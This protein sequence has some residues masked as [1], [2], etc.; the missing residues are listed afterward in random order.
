M[1]LYMIAVSLIR[2]KNEALKKMHLKRTIK[3]FKIVKIDK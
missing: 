1:S 3:C 2:C